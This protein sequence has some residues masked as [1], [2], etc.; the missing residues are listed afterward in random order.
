VAA[1]LL[2]LL[3][4]RVATRSSPTS[5]PSLQR[6][7]AQCLRHPVTFALFLL[8]VWAALHR[9]PLPDAW[10]RRGD[11]VLFIIGVLVLSVGSLRAYG[12]LIAWYTGV[13]REKGDTHVVQFAPLL[14]KLGRLFIVLIAVT[15]VLQQF[16]VNVASLVVSLGVG[17]LAVG[18][19]AQDTL[20]NMFAGFTILV[21]QPFRVGDRIQLATGEIGDVLWIGMRSTQIHSVDDAILVVPNNLLT[22]DRVVNQSRPTRALATRIPVRVVWGT[23]VAA[24]KAILEESTRGIPHI[25]PARPPVVV[26][27]ALA[28]QGIDLVLAFFVDDYLHQGLVRSTILDRVQARFAAAG[29]Q[30]PLSATMSPWHAPAS[31][32]R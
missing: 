7:L 26:T 6:R 20:S 5:P 16:G 3:V 27:T 10:F 15:T 28:D 8:G 18:L 12:V 4:E 31:T 17:S 21:D 9:L 30:T 24:V 22:K 29:I 14:S 25:D 1:R 19:A 11:H 2:S 23:D 32:S 13:A